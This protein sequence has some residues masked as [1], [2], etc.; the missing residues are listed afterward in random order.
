MASVCP[1]EP[2]L[3]REEVDARHKNWP[4]AARPLRPRSP[5]RADAHQDLARLRR[6]KVVALRRSRPARRARGGRVRRG[7]F[8]I[9]ARRQGAAGA[10]EECAHFAG[11]R[12]TRR[13]I[14]LGACRP[15][16]ALAGGVVERV[17][18]PAVLERDGA[19]ARG[20]GIRRR[21]GDAGEA[22]KQNKRGEH[23][24]NAQSRCHFGLSVCGGRCS[25]APSAIRNRR[26][27]VPPRA[28]GLMNSSTGTPSPA[29]YSRAGQ[30]S[31]ITPS[32]PCERSVAAGRR[33]P[34]R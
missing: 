10:V 14:A 32:H 16:R 26:S 24:G 23:A 33:S 1:A 5:R 2:R 19:P 4:S 18:I 30:T 3:H 12:A 13:A 17:G 34:S 20:G 15:L 21:G 28:G 29:R 7:P 22:A 11:A 31:R 8:A 25:S 9:V 27:G 6:Q